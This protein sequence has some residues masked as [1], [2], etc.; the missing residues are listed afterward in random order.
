LQ[1]KIAFDI[2]SAM[3]M[4]EIRR[5]IPQ[6]M[7]TREKE[8][9]D[10]QSIAFATATFY[11]DWKPLADGATRNI[12]D[13][14]GIRGD[15][16]LATLT[17][18]RLNG[19]QIAV[20]DGGSSNA[21]RNILSETI[22]KPP[23]DER[24]KG[25]SPSRRQ[26]FGE[27]SAFNGVK[28]IAW[29]EPEKVSMATDNNL[30]KAALPILQGN[31][32]VVIPKRDTFAFMTYPDEQVRWEQDANK[33]F[34]EIL[35]Q[36]D[37]LPRNAEVLDVW[38]GPRLFKN[39]PDILK[40]F[41][42]QWERDDTPSNKK[43]VKMDPDLWAGATFLPVVAKLYQDKLDGKPP[44]VVSVPVAYTH[45]YEQTIT[46]QDSPVFT[47]KREQQSRN[48]LNATAALV[49]VFSYDSVHE[50]PLYRPDQKHA[51]K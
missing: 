23:S 38:F 31:A 6:E 17:A 22:G 21:F 48:I 33:K 50:R 13:V 8:L 1:S 49:Q 19:F 4:T 12:T 46:E 37:L 32:D 11:R 3:V 34:S 15:L 47:A 10:P 43:D 18:A 2:I 41:L 9:V 26:V 40:F 51:V 29:V 20:V 24:Q 14:D 44:R 42:H 30:Q 27:A 25:M 7:R 16:A 45:P 35:R 36:N 5:P 28:V 39:D